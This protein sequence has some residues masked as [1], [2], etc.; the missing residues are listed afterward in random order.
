MIE[1]HYSNDV[2]LSKCNCLFFKTHK[3]KFRNNLSSLLWN[4]YWHTIGLA[5]CQALIIKNEK[6]IMYFPLIPHLNNS[7]I[8]LYGPLIVCLSQHLLSTNYD[9][10]KR[11]IT[12]N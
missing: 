9:L 5:R 4:K 3:Y 7:S 10:H 8:Y 1:G 11:K 12:E 2:E 6:R